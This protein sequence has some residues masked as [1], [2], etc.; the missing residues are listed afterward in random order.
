MLPAIVRVAKWVNS[1]KMKSLNVVTMMVAKMVDY[2][3]MPLYWAICQLANVL[4]AGLAIS[5]K[6]VSEYW[7]QPNSQG[8]V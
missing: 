6:Y 1:A 7:A 3:W 5:V 2:V 4:A 8:W